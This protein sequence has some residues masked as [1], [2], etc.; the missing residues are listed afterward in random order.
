MRNKTMT[1]GL[2]MI[3]RVL[4]LCL[5]LVLAAAAA[6]FGITMMTIS[7]VLILVWGETVLHWLDITPGLF[8]VK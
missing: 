4:A 5:C 7:W 6:G 1:N 2:K 8:L 3:R